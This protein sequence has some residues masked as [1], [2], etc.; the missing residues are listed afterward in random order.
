V[1]SR[2]YRR[3]GKFLV[4]TDGPDGTMREYEVAYTFGVAPL[5]Q[6]LIAMPGGRYQALAHGDRTQRTRLARNGK[7][8]RRE[9]CYRRTT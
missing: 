3:D 5:Q 6:Y 7:M 9:I 4:Y 2:F 1:T 8:P